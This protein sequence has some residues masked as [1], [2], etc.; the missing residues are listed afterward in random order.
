MLLASVADCEKLKGKGIDEIVCVSPNDVFVTEAWG[1][2]QKAEGKVRLPSSCKLG[3]LLHR[4]AVKPVCS[5]VV[6]LSF[7]CCAL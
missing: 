7:C 5:R 1:R 3:F 4:R 6:L 2:D